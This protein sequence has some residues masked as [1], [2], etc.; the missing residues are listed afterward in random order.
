MMTRT[1]A[2]TPR[3]FCIYIKSYDKKKTSTAKNIMKSL[4]NVYRY[5]TDSWAK[6]SAH[7]T[8]SRPA[9][10]LFKKFF[11]DFLCKVV[12]RILGFA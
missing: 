12:R 3:S 5:E 4:Y 1:F 10:F 6:P 7:R 2:V 11:H 9:H 8:G